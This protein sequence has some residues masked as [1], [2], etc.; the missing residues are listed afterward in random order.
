MVTAPGTW[1]AVLLIFAA[2]VFG[3]FGVVLFFEALRDRARRRQVTVQLEQLAQDDLRHDQG[4]RNL[5]RGT[6]SE[7]PKWLEPLAS[8]LPHLRDADTLIEQ[9]ALNW[10]SQTFLILSGGFALAFGLGATIAFGS[11]IAFV[12]GAAAG[13]SMP[14]FHLRRKRE[15]R[16]RA[17]EEGL[18]EAIDL[19][20]RALRA[21]HPLSS[22][23][24]MVADETVD[25][26]AGEFRRVFEEQRFGLALEES[27]LGMADRIPLVD[28]RIFVTAVLIQR[29]VGGNLA[30]ILDKLSYVIRQRFSIMR[31]LRTFTAQGRLSG[32]IL[33]SLPIM[34][35]LVLLLINRDDM[36]T[37]ITHPLGRM[38]MMVAIFL[39]VIGYLLISR[40]VKIEV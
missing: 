27:L 3:T 4:A 23:L 38:L 20:G 24:K 9:A 21:G 29:E 5:F 26:I 18:P 30:E 6:R 7:G 25:P 32:Y 37:F 31:Q 8:R 36:M 34:L 39:Q 28:I 33:G 13:A 1:T 10:S 40:I 11:L 22:G 19:L 2:V 14:Y 16:M 12:A 15:K 35:G 17:F